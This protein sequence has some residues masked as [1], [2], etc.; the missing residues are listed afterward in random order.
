M[1]PMLL[2]GATWSGGSCGDKY[3]VS[4]EGQ[5]LE[6]SQDRCSWGSG[7]QVYTSPQVTLTMYTHHA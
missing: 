4:G 7:V 2:P 5:A 3:R 6:A 1:G